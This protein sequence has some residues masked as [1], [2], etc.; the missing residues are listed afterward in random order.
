MYQ[1]DY[2]EKFNTFRPVWLFEVSHLNRRSASGCDAKAQRRRDLWR[3]GLVSGRA[4]WIA[5]KRGNKKLERKLPKNETLTRRDQ[6]SGDFCGEEVALGAALRINFNDEGN[7][8]WRREFYR[9]SANQHTNDSAIFMTT[10]TAWFMRNF[11][12]H[13]ESS[14]SVR[15]RQCEIV[16]IRQ[17]STDEKKHWKHFQI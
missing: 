5:E 6:I 8:Y 7:F 2:V 10:R 9:L 3:N 11:L 12:E 16:F 4:E 14:F 13:E 17:N 1:D 15:C